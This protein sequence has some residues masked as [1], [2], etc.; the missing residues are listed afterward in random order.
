ML[1]LLLTA[2][3]LSALAAEGRACAVPSGDIA[4][5]PVV[6]PAQVP[7]LDL[8]TWVGPELLGERRAQRA[9]RTEQ[10][11]QIPGAVAVGL[12]GALTALASA[13]PH[14]HDARWP[15]RLRGAFSRHLFED[16]RRD[17]LLR[18]LGR[19]TDATTLVAWVVR[20]DGLPLTAEG[21]PGDVLETA[22]GPV[23]VDHG[24][25]PYLVTLE[26][27]FALIDR[28]GAVL[29]AGQGVA[30]DLLGNRSGPPRIGRA[31]ARRWVEGE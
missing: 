10:L 17:R 11:A 2:A 15:P 5:L 20:L 19:A 25:E 16:D 4:V 31:V 14:F 21:F 9:L 6:G 18:R 30:N 28:T 22:S 8:D 27:G 13:P 7:A 24:E 1:S 26:G 12:P 29:C 23:V 3:L